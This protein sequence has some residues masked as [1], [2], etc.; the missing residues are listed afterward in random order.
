MIAQDT[1][2][3]DKPNERSLHVS[4][5]VRGG[6]IVFIGLSL[7]GVMFSAF[8]YHSN[9]TPILVLILTTLWIAGVSVLDDLFHLPVKPRF[10]VQ[11]FTA[12]FISLAFLSGHLDFGLFQW[13]NPCLLYCTL[14]IV[15][16]WSVNHFN[17]MDGLDGFCASQALFLFSAYAILFGIYHA[18][19]YQTFC[20]ILIACLSGFLI[21]NFPPAQLFMGDVGSASLG[22]ITIVIALI[23]QQRYQIPMIYWF[24][25]NG[26]FLF[27]S[28]VTLLRR[29]INKEQW[30]APHRSHA[31]QRLKQFGINTPGILL[32]QLI[33]NI[34]SL[35]S[36]SLLHFGWVNLITVLIFQ[37]SIL[38]GAYLVVEN[39][40][41]M[42]R[43]QNSMH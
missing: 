17:F 32:G 30:L 22:L 4:P 5:T 26:L 29:M 11:A 42:Y 37:L 19:D 34:L 16:L 24:I 15:V 8:Y 28:S 14:F 2:L 25:L 21:F 12:A 27:D 39:I 40:F 9:W 43:K 18:Y 3:M 36:I 23:G 6:G 1:R 41:P 31:Y 35:L 10:I 33:I 20:Y 38:L 7:I 13:T